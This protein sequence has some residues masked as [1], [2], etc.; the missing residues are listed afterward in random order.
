MDHEFWHERWAEQ[1][2]GFHQPEVNKYLEKFFE[3]LNLADSEQVFVP[4]C[5]KSLDMLWLREQNCSVLGVEISETACASFFSEN[6]IDIEACPQGDFSAR[7]VDSI[8]LLCGDFFRLSADELVSVSAVYDRAALIALPKEMRLR[9]VQRL[10][11]ILP[12]G[13]KI[14][15]ITLEFEGEQGPPFNVPANEVNELFSP[16]FHITR[17]YEERPADPKDAGRTEVVWLL[18]DEMTN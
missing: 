15:L 18:S 7:E 8:K 4:L 1:R 6:G 13:V 12:A 11:D 2:I 14:L 16:R 3:R 9:Y 5:G 10:L 17:L